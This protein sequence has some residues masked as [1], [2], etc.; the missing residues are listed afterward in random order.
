MANGRAAEEHRQRT[1]PV[2]SLPS[3]AQPTAEPSQG[4]Q[5]RACAV[6]PTRSPQAAAGSLT[7]GSGCLFP[8]GV[9]SIFR[10]SLTGLSTPPFRRLFG[11]PLFFPFFLLS[12]PPTFHTRAGLAVSAVAAPPPC[13]FLGHPPELGLAVLRAARAAALAGGAAGPCSALLGPSAWTPVSGG[14]RRGCTRAG[15]APRPG[16]RNF[17]ETGAVFCAGE[18][19]PGAALRLP[20]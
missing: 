5:A 2:R 17:S 15:P 4:G 12:P 19:E 7:F 13:R 1:V 6:Q 20:D 14:L 9:T 18:R 11:L 8:S 16:A 3:A 10:V